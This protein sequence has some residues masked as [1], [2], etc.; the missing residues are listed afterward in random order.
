[1][2]NIIR[3]A[4]ATCREKEQPGSGGLEVPCERSAG[5][6]ALVRQ[7]PVP[8]DDGGPALVLHQPLLP[9]YADAP[10][11]RVVTDDLSI[12]IPEYVLRSLQRVDDTCY[13]DE[14]SLAKINIRSS[15]YVGDGA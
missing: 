5:V 3:A 6:G 7:V 8:E 14:R 4:A 2:T 13:V 11:G 12:V 15:N 10:P 9:H 1:M